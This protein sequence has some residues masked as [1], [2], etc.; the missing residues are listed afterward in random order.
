MLM[1]QPRCAHFI[2]RLGMGFEKLTFMCGNKFVLIVVIT[3][4][5]R[6]GAKRF[7]VVIGLVAISLMKIA[8]FMSTEIISHEL[9]CLRDRSAVYDWM[10]LVAD[11]WESQIA[12]TKV[13]L[14]LENKFK[15][16]WVFKFLRWAIIQ[17]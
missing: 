5:L 12:A 7:F 8:N 1:M 4:R 16:G 9:V 10:E 15:F 14:F 3:P 17:N 2:L 11:G 6:E 13:L